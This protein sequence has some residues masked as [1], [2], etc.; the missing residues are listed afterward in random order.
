MTRINTNVSSLTAQK[1]LAQSNSALQQALT[2]LSTGLRINAGKDDPAGLIAS[3][4]LRSD[5]TSTQKAISNS[6]RANQMI[7]TADSALGQVSSLLN[8]I[9]GLVTEAANKGAMSDDQIAANQLQVDSSLEAINRIAQTT[10]FQGKR[11]LD[12]SLDFVTKSWSTNQA[13]VTD[14]H[15]DQA[16]IASGGTA[17][18]VHVT[19]MATKGTVSTKIDDAAGATKSSAIIRFGTDASNYDELKVEANTA[20][21][22]YDGVQVDIELSDSVA[23]GAAVASFNGSDKITVLINSGDG[24]TDY[25][26]IADAI[27]DGTGGLFTGTA[28]QT[29]TAD[30]YITIASGAVTNAGALGVSGTTGDG[31]N[32]GATGAVGAGLQDDVVFELSGANG[33]QVFSFGKGT[34]MDQVISA[35]NLVSDATGVQA[36]RNGTTTTQLDL[37]AT[38]YGSAGFVNVNV[39][40]EGSSG[41]FKTNFATS[42]TGTR[43]AGADIAA[44]VN[45]I[46]AK[47]NGNTLSVSTASLAMSATLD[48][49]YDKGTDV[50]FT[51]SDGGALF[52]LGPDVV[53]NQQA[54]IGIQSVNTASLGGAD[55]RLYELASGDDAALAKD[56]TAGRQ[57][58]GRSD[59]QGYLPP[60]SVGCL[61]E[62]N[63]R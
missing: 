55:G 21:A 63:R 25:A 61:P 2:R 9:R 4:A 6:Q 14:L 41:I 60:R 11:L 43:Q 13:K 62:V 45:G 7:A 12:G 10:T 19:T 16:S 56:P 29:G 34:K 52:Q 5:I 8:D 15:I 40:S 47:G 22:A 33:T 42:G 39:I 18:D 53:T 38:S 37:K 57:N 17:V 48:D 51:I 20:G 1:T 27:T 44:T 23:A 32:G 50:T 49:T 30:G 3:E 28:T 24:D 58:R 36:E 26:D 35:I 31:E 46:A 59:Q 54:R